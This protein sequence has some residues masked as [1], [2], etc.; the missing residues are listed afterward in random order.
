MLYVLPFKKDR[1]FMMYPEALIGTLA[2]APCPAV[3]DFLKSYSQLIGRFIGF[4]HSCIFLSLPSKPFN[5]FHDKTPIKKEKE[6]ISSSEQDNGDLKK[7]V[8]FKRLNRRKGSLFDQYFRIE[9]Q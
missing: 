6:Q 9:K 4:F 7:W 1:A 2:V 3:R 5:I 8:I